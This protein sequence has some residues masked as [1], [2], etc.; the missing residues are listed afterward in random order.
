[1]DNGA[2]DEGAKYF[3][4]GL[5]DIQKK[6][7]LRF[8][9]S[10]APFAADLQHVFA[11]AIALEVVSDPQAS[12]NLT[13]RNTLSKKQKDMRTSARR[14]NRYIQPKLIDVQR[15]EAELCKRT[16][17]PSDHIDVDALFEESLRAQQGSISYSVNG[18]MTDRGTEAG[19]M[20]PTK[21]ASVVHT[22]ETNGI[23][24]ANEQAH[25]DA[26]L[27]A[28][29]A[30]D[31]DMVDAEEDAKVDKDEVTDEAVIRLQ[32]EPGGPTIPISNSGEKPDHRNGTG[33]PAT[34]ISSSLSATTTAPAL[35]T[36]DSTNPSL[37]ATDP[38]TPPH[39][40]HILTNGNGI[41]PT[42]PLYD[43]GVMWYLEPF[44]P[45][46]TT[47]HDERWG[48]RDALRQM[49]EELS[50]LGSEALEDLLAS[51]DLD[52]VGAARDT[53]EQREEVADTGGKLAPPAPQKKKAKRKRSQF[54]RRVR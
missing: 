6:L 40:N 31:V 48:G 12:E 41:G 29:A 45:R 18:D 43:G 2:K 35:S 11:E 50:E 51:D 42:D 13:V 4:P 38:L 5:Q 16:L 30:E 3:K 36:S 32:L 21:A 26:Q 19:H 44:S 8:Y 15:K 34:S 14:I 33:N 23:D 49:S 39:L 9:T 7:E 54:G 47:V 37:H 52:G 28:D 27:Q 22:I 46:G 10:A 53:V 25:V 20:S 24:E 17:N 1:M